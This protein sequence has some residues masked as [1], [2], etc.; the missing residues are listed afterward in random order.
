MTMKLFVLGATGNTGREVVALALRRGHQ[1]TA[2]VRSPHKLV[3][4]HR[5]LRVVAGDLCDAGQLAASMDGH[6][7][8]ISVLGPRPL[9]AFRPSN[10]LTELAAGTV[11]GMQ[12]AGVPRLA[13]LS[14]ALLFPGGGVA[15][16]FMRWLLRHHVEDLSGMEAVTRATPFDWTIARPPR[17]VHAL[18]EAYTCSGG[19]LPNGAFSMSFRAT[20]AFLVDCVEQAAFVREVVGLRGAADV[21]A[22]GCDPAEGPGS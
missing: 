2:F 6:D 16:A 3:Q 21:P 4:A 5:A 11:A 10:L 9:K 8:V 14:A 18:D 15:F 1:V 13:I 7:A 22:T 20:A 12:S 17:L 19:T